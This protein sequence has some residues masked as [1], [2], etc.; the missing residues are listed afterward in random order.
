MSVAGS[1]SSGGGASRG[2]AISGEEVKRMIEEFAKDHRTLDRSEESGN[3]DKLCE[4]LKAYLANGAKE[5]LAS[6]KGHPVLYQ[7][8]SDGTDLSVQVYKTAKIGERRVRRRGGRQHEFLIE[9]AWL[10][11]HDGLGS[12]V[13]QPFFRDPSA[14]KVG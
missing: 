2:S 6:A 4:V 12:V 14:M 1:S 8:S 7:Y 3:C 5:F 9:R 13:S 11:K 10:T